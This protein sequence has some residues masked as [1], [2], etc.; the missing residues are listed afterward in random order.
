MN[1]TTQHH[2]YHRGVRMAGRWKHLKSTVLKW[3]R[4][5]MSKAQ[6]V[7]LPKWVGHIP[8]CI[9]ALMM[10]SAVV[11]GG[12]II[13]SSAVL[14]GAI[15]VIVGGSLPSEKS[16]ADSVDHTTNSSNTTTEY[17]ADGEFGPGWYADNY[18]V[19]DDY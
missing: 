3:D 7:N 18:K 2:A 12:V 11:F 15:G 1:D 19:S 8:M 10:V 16:M 5:C 13:A 6:S 14:L 9:L 4:A 17:R